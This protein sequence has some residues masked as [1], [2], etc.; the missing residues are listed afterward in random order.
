MEVMH[1]GGALPFS[2]FA[3]NENSCSK[4]PSRMEISAAS[5]Y[6]TKGFIPWGMQMGHLGY[7]G[8]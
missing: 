1:K 6:K 3:Y 8:Y 5:S 2:R 7:P 4:K